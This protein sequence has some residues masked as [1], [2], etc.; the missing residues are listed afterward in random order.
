MTRKVRVTV[1]GLGL[2]GGRIHVPALEQLSEAKLVAVCDPDP[3]RRAGPWPA[4]VFAGWEDALEVPA[5]AVVVATPPETHAE[6]AAAALSLGR[7]VY[8]EKPMAATVADGLA[9]ER[10]ATAGLVLQVGFAYRFH[11][12]WRSVRSLLDRGWLQPHLVA[13]A[14]FTTAG[15]TGWRDPVLDVACHHLDLVSWL[16][17]H[18]V[19]EVQVGDGGAVVARWPGGVEL[20]GRYQVGAPADVVTLGDG[21]RQ[22]TVDR[23]RGWRLRGSP[24]PPVPGLVMARLMGSGIEKSF[25]RALAAFVTAADGRKDAV[26]GAAGPADGIAA[27]A[28]VS[29]LRRSAA[30]GLREQVT[31]T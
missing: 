27:I 6:L 4:P 5:D 8:V 2:A 11:P 26:D 18:R 20:V 21:K 1:L 14:R 15:G 29:A 3:A 16:I 12:L 23:I 25:S 24:L 13:Q 17:G 28:V 22:V 10:A 19:L 31:L 7:H 30:S 9:L